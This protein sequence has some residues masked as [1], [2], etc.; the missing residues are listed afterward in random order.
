MLFSI[1]IQSSL[2]Q[3]LNQFQVSDLLFLLFLLL[4]NTLKELFV[5]TYLLMSIGPCILCHLLLDK[6]LVAS[7]L[8]ELL[9]IIKEHYCY[10]RIYLSFLL[11]LYFQINCLRHFHAAYAEIE[12]MCQPHL[13]SI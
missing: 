9:S 6:S 1:S 5:Y 11:G 3:C 2:V 13:L 4:T 10:S 12:N 7:I 8:F